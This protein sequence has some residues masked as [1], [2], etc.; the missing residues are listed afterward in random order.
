M[1]NE[2]IWKAKKY[3]TT[4]TKQITDVPTHMASRQCWYDSRCTDKHGWHD[5]VDITTDLQIHMAGM[6][7]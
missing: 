4:C 3:F 5:N 7:V 6:T 1:R 2:K